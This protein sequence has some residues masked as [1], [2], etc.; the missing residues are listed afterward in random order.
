MSRDMFYGRYGLDP[1]SIFLM[2]LSV[3]FFSSR[4]RWL[5]IIGAVLLIIALVRC[6]STNIEKRQKERYVF[7]NATRA[8]AEFF[9]RIYYKLKPVFAAIGR[10]F[11]SIGKFFSGIGKH[12]RD[13]NARWKQRKDYIF[14]RCP[15]C[16][17]MLRLPRHKGKLI[18]TCPMCRY[19]FKKKT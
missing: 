7:S 16:K 6:F 4:N 11:R 12:F 13:V 15:H 3:A 5:M 9:R 8:T 1:L 18:V 10:F 19:E 2:C 14:V 17:N